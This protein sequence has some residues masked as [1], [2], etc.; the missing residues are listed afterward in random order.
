MEIEDDMYVFTFLPML[1]F[2][3]PITQRYMLQYKWEVDL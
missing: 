3:F 1:T 2:T